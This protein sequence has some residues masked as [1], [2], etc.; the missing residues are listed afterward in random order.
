MKNNVVYLHVKKGTD[1]VFYV[2][3]GKNK[4]RAFSTS[5]RSR[6]WNN[7]V[8]KY[9]LE[10]RIVN[11]GLNNRDADYIEAEL[12]E[13]FGMINDGGQLVNLRGGG[14]ANYS[15]T[16]ETRDKMSEKAKGRPAW[17]K[18]ISAKTY[19]SDEAI[20][21]ISNSARERMKGNTNSLG[22]IN[23]NSKRQ[24]AMRTPKTPRVY[25]HK[26]D[27]NTRAIKITDPNGFE[28]GC[29][30]DAYTAW[31]L[32]ENQLNKIL[33]QG[34]SDWD[35][36]KI[37]D[38]RTIGHAQTEETRRKQSEAAKRRWAAVRKNRNNGCE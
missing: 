17:N 19:L 13:V 20:R 4:R 5:G 38:K 27:K 32:T 16:K 36:S 7:M 31:S 25:D 26:G 8:N 2:G 6:Y 14:R 35:P 22:R 30:K 3:V 34:I 33:K 23:P 28:W 24:I 9:G 37:T 15:L 18:G 11:K 12:I 1:Y 21:N 10:V 29:K